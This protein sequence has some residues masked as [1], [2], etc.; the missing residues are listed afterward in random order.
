[1]YPAALLLLLLVC[2]PPLLHAADVVTSSS[3]PPVLLSDP[4]TSG[5]IGYL[6]DQ[7]PADNIVLSPMRQLL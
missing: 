1:M 3:A 4:L 5:L 7:Q 2:G 6:A